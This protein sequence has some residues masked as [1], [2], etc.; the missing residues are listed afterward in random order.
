M[1]RTRERWSDVRSVAVVIVACA[2]FGT[3]VATP[4]PASPVCSVFDR[5]PCAPTTCSVFRRGPCIPEVQYPIGQDLRLTIESAA[6]KVSQTSDATVG[7]T[8]RPDA[9]DGEDKIDSIAGLFAALRACWVPPAM[10]DASLGVE[11]SVRFAFK[12]SGE[13]MGPPRVT[14]V[15]PDTPG[16]VRKRYHNAITEA[17]ERCTPMP[18]TSGMGSAVAGRPIAIRYVDN[19]SQP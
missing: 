6:T 11:M 8:A 4:A 10:E 9:D 16:E 15:T 19:R 3:I 7:H 1:G 2:L 14:Y 17:L 13:I 18:F 12:R 5:R